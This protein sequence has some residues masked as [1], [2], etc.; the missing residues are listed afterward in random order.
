V[1]PIAWSSKLGSV[2]RDYYYYFFF[3]P[4]SMLLKT[5]SKHRSTVQGNEEN[6][7]RKPVF[8]KSVSI[9]RLSESVNIATV[10]R[11]L[12]KLETET[13]FRI[14]QIYYFFGIKNVTCRVDRKHTYFF[15]ALFVTEKTINITQPSK[16][17]L[18]QSISYDFVAVTLVRITF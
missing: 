10:K 5:G 6:S 17:T 9:K 18:K 8:N 7:N 11:L 4:T 12:L 15:L 3:E 16:K 13:N 14:L 2:G 1:F